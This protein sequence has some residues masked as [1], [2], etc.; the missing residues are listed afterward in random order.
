MTAVHCSGM[1]ENNK[2]SR[3]LWAQPYQSKQEKDTLGI[4]PT[5][6][7]LYIFGG[8]MKKPEIVSAHVDFSD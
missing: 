8:I 6:M 5:L 2:Y 3:G 1:D 7:G 4:D